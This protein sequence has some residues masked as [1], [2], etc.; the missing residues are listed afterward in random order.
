V[1]YIEARVSKE[2]ALRFFT[3]RRLRNA[4]GLL[5]SRRRLLPSGREI[6]YIERVWMPFYIVTLRV[7]SHRGPGEV[8]VSVEGYSGSFAIFQMHE[9]LVE[10]ALTEEW[11]PPR[12]SEEEAVRVGREQLL[13]TILRRRGQQEKPVVEETLGI[14]VIYYPFWVYYFERRPGVLDIALQDALTAE[15]GGNRN[16]AG[17]LDAFV[18]HSKIKEDRA[19]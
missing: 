13:Q 11:F 17:L 5:R 12:M 4:Y 18:C 16:R 14:D 2:T 8:T 1:K 15:R 6:P 10:G 19:Q 9:D 3:R 7:V